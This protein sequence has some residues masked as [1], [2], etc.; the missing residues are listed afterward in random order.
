MSTGCRS[1]R[2]GRAGLLTRRAFAGA[3]VLALAA[4]WLS[5]CGPEPPPA[6]VE[7]TLRRGGKP[8]DNCLVTFFPEP[9]QETRWPHSTGLTD[10]RGAYRLHGGNGQEGAGVGRHRVTVQDLS[11]STG[12]RR[13][14]HGT[15]DAEADDS[16]PPPVRRSR[17]AERY[18]SAT[19][20]PL[21]VE[22][23]PGHQTIDLEIH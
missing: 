21:R 1:L 13:R 7:G 8:L 20:T 14:D 23:K 17:V 15:V 18:L 11:V 6:T 19:D 4:T 5:G 3:S 10:Q 16:P 12:V 9:G 2:P 22:I